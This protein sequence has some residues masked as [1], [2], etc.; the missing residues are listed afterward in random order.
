MLP[1]TISRAFMS[2]YHL[3]LDFTR[4]LG[5]LLQSR[6]ALAVENLFLRKQLALYLDVK[7]D[8]AGPR[9]PP[10]SLWPWRPDCLIGKRL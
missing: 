9:T 10:V 4:F 6:S 2:F 7:C 3:S 8:L 1:D 5:V